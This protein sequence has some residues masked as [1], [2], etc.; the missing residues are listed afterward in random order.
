LS[1]PLSQPSIEEQPTQQDLL[2]VYRF[3]FEREPDGTLDLAKVLSDGVTWGGVRKAIYA[4]PKFKE[5]LSR[6]HS[7]SK[8]IV[9]PA[10]RV[11]IYVDEPKLRKMFARIEE[12][13]TELSN[14]EPYWAVLTN[15]NYL[16][17]NIDVNRSKFFEGGKG[18]M[19]TLLQFAARANIDLHA[20]DTCFE[21]GCGVGRVTVHLAQLF[22]KL[23]AW[24]IAEPMIAEAKVNLSEFGCNNVELHAVKEFSEFEDLKPFDCFFSRIVLQHNPPPVSFYMLS[25]ILDKLR[26]GGIAL[27]QIPTYGFGYSFDADQYLASMPKKSFEMHCV[28]QRAIFQL[29]E[30]KEYSI[31][32]LR[33]DGATGLGSPWISNTFLVQRAPAASAS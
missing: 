28:P 13:F 10:T 27:F 23:I 9:G 11:D 19:N 33:E 8:S 18:D 22:N 2:A 25:K 5:F 20:L 15:D 29:L 4:S 32:E 31:L 14:T 21:L 6:R 30:Q 17:E 24:D 16:R 3:L 12:G 26:P 7:G 1:Q